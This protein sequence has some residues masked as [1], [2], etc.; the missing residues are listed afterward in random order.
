M[1]NVITRIAPS[2]SGYFHLE[3][4][5]TALYN[6]L[7]AKANKGTFILRIDDTNQDKVEQQYIDYIYEQMNLFNLDYDLTFKQ[8]DR[9]DRYKE[10]A[11]LIG[12]LDEDN[13][14]FI[15]MQDY[16]MTILRANGYPL[17]NFSSILDDYDY[18]ITHIIRG[19]DHISNLDKQIEIWN[20]INAVLNTN[21]PFPEVIHVGLLLDSSTG[22]KISKRDGTGLV[23]DYLKYDNLALLN[24]LLKLGWSSK[25]PNFD[26]IYPTLTLNQMVEVFLNGN[27]NKANTKV[28][29][30]KLEWFNKK[31]NYK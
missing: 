3:T 29:L 5:R 24:W 6:Y 28:Y 14:I 19:V 2:P 26:K 1:N 21:K 31:L 4:L 8:S 11:L 9:L 20:I 17:Y 13:S 16:K 25:N 18:D 22:K 10:I 27:I 15:Q 23:S 12:T 7:Y 30:D